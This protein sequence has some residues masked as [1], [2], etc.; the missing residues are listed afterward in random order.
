M[1]Y[2]PAQIV[3]ECQ[4]GNTCISAFAWAF[5]VECAS[6]MQF[7]HRLTTIACYWGAWNAIRKL[8]RCIHISKG[9]RIPAGSRFS[10][11][12]CFFILR[13]WIKCGF[14]RMPT[15]ILPVC[16]KYLYSSAMM[17]NIKYLLLFVGC[18]SFGPLF[19]TN[20]LFNISSMKM[21]TIRYIR[22]GVRVY[23]RLCK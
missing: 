16:Y 19:S 13:N 9:D 10:L 15:K 22:V 20:D 11:D 5:S 14:R 1:L 12:L 23:C 4:I 6:T 3:N 8:P 21:K 18:C 2:E 7:V 17:S